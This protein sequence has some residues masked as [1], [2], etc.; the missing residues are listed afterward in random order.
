MARPKQAKIPAGLYANFA[1]MDK[2]AIIGFLK[3]KGFAVTG[4]WDALW[5]QS[6][7][8]AKT[9][10]GETRIDLLEDIFNTVEKGIGKGTNRQKMANTLAKAMADKGWYF[11]RTGGSYQLDAKK[12]LGNLLSISDEDVDALKAARLKQSARRLKLIMRQNTQSAFMAG[13]Y[14][15]QVA[16][17]HNRPYWQYLAVM[18]G[19]TRDSHAALHGKVLRA[20][21]PIWDKIYPPNGFNCRCRVSALSERDRQRLGLSVSE[22]EL[23]PHKLDKTN[24][25]GSP[26]YQYELKKKIPPAPPFRKDLLGKTPQKPMKLDAG[27][28]YNAGKIQAQ[29]FVPRLGEITAE[30]QHL[31]NRVTDNDKILPDNLTPGQYATAFLAEFGVKRGEVK[32]FTD[33]TGEVIPI[34]ED[35]LT[36]REQGKAPEPKSNKEGRGKYMRLLAETFKDPDEVWLSWEKE[37]G[38]WHLKR[39]YLRVIDLGNNLFALGV[40]RREKGA[41]YGSTVFQPNP[42]KQQDLLIEYL[43][44]RR[45]GVRLYKRKSDSE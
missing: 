12:E 40:F 4:S 13:A 44:D 39:H 15:R 10:A 2:T 9:I 30:N 41:W 7:A 14:Q 37:G 6:H 43:D 33:V 8:Y 18:D 16:N 20:D 23:K 38:K 35:L 1:H 34:S 21:D 36:K 5:E 24:A 29:P 26:R 42:K 31:L 11:A 27:F 45:K 32:P 17:I 22:F 25:D 3:R 19:S 28:A